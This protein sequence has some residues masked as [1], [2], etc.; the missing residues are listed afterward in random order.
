MKK[1]YLLIF[2]ILL[3]LTSTGCDTTQNSNVSNDEKVLKLQLTWDMNFTNN[4]YCGVN[5][6]PITLFLMEGLYN[7][8]DTV[9]YVVPVLADGMPIYES[10]GSSCVIKIK[11]NA[12]WHNGEDF[13]AQDVWAFY[14]LQ[15]TT[16]TN[17]MSSIE[18]VDDK[19]LKINW[20]PNKP[21][22]N[23]I[24]TKLLALDLNGSIKYT[25]YAEYVDKAAQLLENCKE[26]DYTKVSS[27]PFG[28]DIDVA[29]SVEYSTNYSKFQSC[30]PTFYVATGA[31]KLESYTARQM[32]LVKNPDYFNADKIQFEKII[33]Y[34]YSDTNQTYN[35][36]IN[37][38]IHYY[39]GVPEENTLESMIS[40]NENLV[41]LKMLDITTIGMNFNMAKPIWQD[42][43]VRKAFQYIF[44]RDEIKYLSNPYAITNYYASNSMPESEIK[45]HLSA[46]HIEKMVKY[47]KNWEEAERLL[48]LAGWSK[49][50][51]SWHDAKGNRVS[52]TMASSN[53][54]PI[55]NNAAVAAQS[56]L[57]AFGIECVLKL[58]DQGALFQ[59]GKA[60][61][62]PY[63]CVIM[64]TEIN[65]TLSHPFGSFNAFKNQYSYFTH[66]PRFNR[67]DQ[68]GNGTA[69]A[70]DINME[71]P[72][73]DGGTGLNGRSTVNFSEYMNLLYAMDEEELELVA[74]SVVVGMSEYMYGV[75]FFQ[76][77]TGSV[78][79][80]GYIDGVALEEKWS[81]ER[82][83]TYIADITSE[84]AI[85]VAQ[86]NLKWSDTTPFIL[87]ILKPKI[88]K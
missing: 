9:D 43:N 75:N 82:N 65:D 80:V 49:K 53:S 88:S 19:T 78:W 24:K 56:Q 15:H 14:M 76:N 74:A 52:I 12:K 32:I 21:L 37:N 64:W 45:K 10:D 63:D 2:S 62:S 33:A 27:A 69:Y 41:H 3:L 70:G 71:F 66:L 77:V 18:I 54:H 20:N 4:Y 29:T 8:L 50:G 42:A 28:K 47:N 25:E 51:N 84:D 79:N 73:I 13:T 55:W 59:N 87:E 22:T 72:W 44:D 60:D 58:A 23:D 86:M 6:H 61:N 39:D 67:G 5:L 46:E 81:Q 30:N 26:A 1:I 48:K 83:L 57:S 7:R 17:Y 36:L 85:K 16:I 38:E 31:F 40:Q 11:E 34:N 35:A 68:L